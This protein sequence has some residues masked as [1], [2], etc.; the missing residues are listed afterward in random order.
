MDKVARALQLAGCVAN[1]GDAFAFAPA[2]ALPVAWTANPQDEPSPEVPG[3]LG[4][5][6]PRLVRLTGARAPFLV[7]G[8]RLP[9]AG[10]SL[11]DADGYAYRIKETPLQHLNPLV[12]FLCVTTAPKAST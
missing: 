4:T 8:A 12:A 1:T 3:Q 2:D 7:A 11:T 10:E 9:K 5:A 6:N